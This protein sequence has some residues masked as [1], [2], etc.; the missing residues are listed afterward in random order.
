M[1]IFA[2]FISEASF[3]QSENLKK[4][5]DEFQYAITVDWDQQDQAVYQS[6]VKIFHEQLEAA[7][8]SQTELYQFLSASTQDDSLKR[9]LQTIL[10]LI[11]LN[12][13]GQEKAQQM[14]D[15]LLHANFSRGAS[16][17]GRAV[18]ITASIAIVAAVFTW[19]IISGVQCSKDPNATIDCKIE[20]NLEAYKETCYC[21]R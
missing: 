20:L 11:S 16:W 9:E 1:I 18:L 13:L 7:H 14:M 19:A 12:Q 5:V 15:E 8:V 10:T 2:I 3:A 6:K 17:N 21:Y 4:I